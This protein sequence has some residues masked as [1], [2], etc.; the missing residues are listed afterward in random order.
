MYVV[1]LHEN[2]PPAHLNF[3]LNANVM[4]VHQLTAS[5]CKASY[6]L[7]VMYQ[8]HSSS[9]NLITSLYLVH[10]CVQIRGLTVWG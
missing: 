6:W 2:M 4:L 1:F 7:W 5:Y 8:V 9:K 10:K 3:C